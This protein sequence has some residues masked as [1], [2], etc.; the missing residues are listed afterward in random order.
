M[1]EP[2]TLTPDPLAPPPADLLRV[3]DVA[4]LLGTSTRSVWRYSRAGRMPPPVRLTRRTVRW[5]AGEL[6]A[7]LDAGRPLGA[8]LGTQAHAAAVAEVA[9]LLERFGSPPVAR[10][11]LELGNGDRIVLP[12]TDDDGPPPAA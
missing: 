7:W 10:I 12:L 11:A 8:K 9:R 1:P 4:A 3:A 2:L 6:R 5:R